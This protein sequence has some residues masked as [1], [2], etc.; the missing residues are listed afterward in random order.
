MT[1]FVRSIRSDYAKVPGVL[2][3]YVFTLS[4]RWVAC[5]GTTLEEAYAE[6]KKFFGSRPDGFKF[7]YYARPWDEKEPRVL[8][9]YRG[10]VV[11]DRG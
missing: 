7:E 5:S 6:A 10:I 2:R 8:P 3:R 1:R 4:G 11:S 9:R